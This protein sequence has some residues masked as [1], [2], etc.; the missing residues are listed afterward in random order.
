MDLAR[1]RAVDL[2]AVDGGGQLL[3]ALYFA[4]NTSGDTISTDLKTHVVGAREA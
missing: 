2:D 3:P 4:F 1:V